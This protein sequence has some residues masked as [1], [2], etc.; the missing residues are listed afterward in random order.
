M[1]D[2]ISKKALLEFIETNYKP[3]WHNPTADHFKD[4][5]T[6]AP[7]IEQNVKC[8]SHPDAP[9]GFCRGA[10]HTANR[11]V[12]ECEWWTPPPQPQT[13]KDAP[14]V[15]SKTSYCGKDYSVGS[16][17]FEKVYVCGEDDGQC[18]WCKCLDYRSPAV[19]DALE[20]AAKIC[21]ELEDKCNK[22]DRPG[23]GDAIRALI[24]KE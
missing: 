6:N 19:K 14:A 22:F 13:V 21:D 17:G 20:K 5:I 15:E 3:Y 11:Y 7:A 8:S 16:G 4:I 18:G 10:S 24:E 1:S 9:H 2:L 12:C 23:C